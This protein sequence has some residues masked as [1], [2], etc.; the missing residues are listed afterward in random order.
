M[1]EAGA[2]AL[3]TYNRPKS[4]NSL[5]PKMLKDMVSVLKWVENQPCVRIIVQTGEGRFFNTGM[6]L[7]DGEGV[8]FAIGSD[9][10]ELNR[11]LIVSK[12][13]L[14]AAVNGPAAGYGVSSL[15]LYDLVYSVPDAYFFTPF[16]KLGMTAEG[17]SSV[18]FPRL[19]GH[20]KAAQLFLTGE[21]INATT[22][23]RMGIISK[24]LPRESFMHDVLQ[25]AH[26]LAQ[27][28]PGSLR[29]TKELMREP[30]RQEL[31]D[32]NDRECALIHGE[33]YG[34]AENLAATKQFSLAQ[35]K[36]RER[37]S[38]I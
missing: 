19:M 16:V 30:I 20:A 32:A 13:T 27:A 24:I 18:S 22:A 9:F 10:H 5:H 28:P 7:V 37:K 25:I 3:V 11:L 8:S 23:E 21:Q 14:I 29:V 33:R 38:K 15:A 6:E 4:G 35:Q 26:H 17:A 36:K 2:V 31:L 12:K 34:S 1:L